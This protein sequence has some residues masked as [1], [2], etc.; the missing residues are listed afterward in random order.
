LLGKKK[1]YYL[2]NKIKG[3]LIMD[4]IME[5]FK[6][7]MD[8]L[9]SKYERVN[10]DLEFL[11]RKCD[12]K[13]IAESGTEN[14]LTALYMEANEEANEKK[15]NIFQKMIER[16][17]AFI[18]KIIGKIKGKKD[19][20]EDDKEYEVNDISNHLSESKKLSSELKSAINSKNPEK[21]SAVNS[22][23][24]KLKTALGIGAGIAVA[25]TVILKK[26]KMRGS[27]LK[28]TVNEVEKVVVDQEAEIKRISNMID[29]LTDLDN[30]KEIQDAMT[31]LTHVNLELVNKLTD[32]QYEMEQE[33]QKREKKIK[34]LETNL[35]NDKKKD[36]EDLKKSK[37]IIKSEIELIDYTIKE[38]DKQ[39]N[40]YKDKIKKI[41]KDLSALKKAEIM[42]KLSAEDT[43]TLKITQSLNIVKISVERL[44]YIPSIKISGDDDIYEAIML[45]RNEY[46]EKYRRSFRY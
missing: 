36:A 22:K 26:K 15:K 9:Q 14:D 30:I 23:I 41:P 4:L 18:Q 38:L 10:K 33:R 45:P 40:K 43:K 3:E 7:D 37:D 6:L 29:N 16:I 12:M 28:R 25:T 11:I 8:I 19:K 39:G 34:E 24:K 13:Y 31:N 5:Q 46:V 27:E 21:I 17:K 35:A 20:I 2:E 44:L 32:K 1:K 42:D